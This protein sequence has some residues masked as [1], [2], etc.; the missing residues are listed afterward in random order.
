MCKRAMY[1]SR[2][3]LL[4]P[5]V[6]GCPHQKACIGKA[7][8]PRWNKPKIIW[9]LTLT[10]TQVSMCQKHMTCSAFYCFGVNKQPRMNPTQFTGRQSTTC[11][12]WK[13][14]RS[15][16]PSVVCEDSYWPSWCWVS[17]KACLIWCILRVE[18]GPTC[19]QWR[20][21]K[22]VH[23]GP[24]KFH[25]HYQRNLNMYTFVNVHGWMFY[26]KTSCLDN[27]HAYVPGCW[28]SA[29][30]KLSAANTVMQN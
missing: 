11:F 14:G 10:A 30:A 16:C 19:L 7:C 3:Y 15:V 6:H 2:A 27:I 8:L 26:L 17:I 12:C 23:L 29:V 24:P 28:V 13:S 21:T 18:I 20:F 1:A 22:E 4:V 9:E 25:W 5:C